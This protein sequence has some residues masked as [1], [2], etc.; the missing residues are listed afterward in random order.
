MHREG[1]ICLE[2]RALKEVLKMAYNKCID[3]T[4]FISYTRRINQHA[5]IQS[6]Y[7]E[8]S[9]NEA[10]RIVWQELND[11][12]IR[13][14]PQK[15][16]PVGYIAGEG[17]AALEKDGQKGDIVTK[18]ATS[19]ERLLEVMEEWPTFRSWVVTWPIDQGMDEERL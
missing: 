15:Q 6:H 8:K 13:S 14:R 7:F 1:A 2:D 19:F 16:G 3:W 18:V 10:L 17:A 12:E 11:D 9:Y 4:D 5:P